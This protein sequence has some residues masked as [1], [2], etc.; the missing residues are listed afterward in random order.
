MSACP[1]PPDLPKSAAGTH[2]HHRLV[3]LLLPW[4]ARLHP[5]NW[6]KDRWGYPQLWW[7]TPRWDTKLKRQGIYRL[8]K[9][10]KVVQWVCGCATGHEMSDTEWG[11]GG[12][13]FVDRHC[14]WCDKVFKVPKAEED[15]P[16]PALNDAADE[17]GFND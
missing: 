11:Y 17:L 16:H 7:V 5:S 10:L 1:I 2:W 9:R 6:R 12:G 8:T 14:R 4:I 3:R 13:R 15:L